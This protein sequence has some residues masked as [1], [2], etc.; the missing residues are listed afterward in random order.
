MK[1]STD[2]GRTWQVAREG[3]R[4]EYRDVYEE[5]DC[6]SDLL[7]SCNSDGIVFEVSADDVVLRVGGIRFAEIMEMTEVAQ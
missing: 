1:V 4:V 2:G 6:T 5:V 7:V 3:V